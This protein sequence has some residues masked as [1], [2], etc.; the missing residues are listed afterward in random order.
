MR[1]PDREQQAEEQRVVA[2]RALDLLDTPEEPAFDR[3][4][5]L[6]ARLLNAPVALVSLVDDTRQWFKSRQGIAVRETP[7][8]Y[9]F[10]LHA[11]ESDAAFIVPDARRD[12]RFRDN[13]LVLGDPSIGAYAGIPIHGPEGHRLGTLCVIYDEPR[14]FEPDELD[15]LADLAASVDTE[16][17]LRAALKHERTAR[18][19]AEVAA[20]ARARFTATV[21]HEI[22]TPLN[23]V[24]GALSLLRDADLSPEAAE[25][26]VLA[27]SSAKF[28]LRL[29][30]DVLDYAK[31][32]SGKWV[33]QECDFGLHH[34]ITNVAD[35]FRLQAQA[36]GVDFHV[37]LADAV[38][39]RVRSDDA[40]LGQILFNLLGNAVKFTDEGRIDVEAAFEP[41]ETNAGTLVL[42]VRDTGIGIAREKQATIFEA[43]TQA[44]SGYT[45]RYNGSG[46]GL[47]IARELAELLGGSLTCESEEGKGSAFTARIPM[48]VVGAV[49]TRAVEAPATHRLGVRDLAGATVL[50]ADD[51]QVN[52]RILEQM[53]SALSVSADTVANGYEAIDA[54]GKRPYD[55]ILM[56]ISMPELDGI[57]AMKAIRQTA[58][59]PLPPIVAVTASAMPGDRENLLAEGFDDYLAKPVSAGELVHM[60]TRVFSAFRNPAQARQAS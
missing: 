56:D 26:L 23:G 34:A 37:Q 53:L 6:A 9:A 52:Q 8:E 41:G 28:L 47:P 57:A 36:K 29:L 22:R 32:E 49:E 42:T 35:L 18:K 2:L 54:A 21:S 11:I 7:R 30:N 38:P 58:R 17:R 16:I 39:R 25:N 24:I 44:D 13:P 27:T 1:Q 60:L 14:Q 46:L 45:R 4:T 51:N 20:A 48:T 10:C 31:L 12:P 3:L 5:S 43:F 55:V 19:E 33:M 40:R 15:I 50:V 59:R